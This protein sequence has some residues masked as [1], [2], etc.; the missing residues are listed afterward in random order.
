M[1]K[2]ALLFSIAWVTSV[3]ARE[4]MKIEDVAPLFNRAHN[5]VVSYFNQPYNLATPTQPAL[6]T[7]SD[8]GTSSNT[9]LIIPP[10]TRGTVYTLQAL[11]TGLGLTIISSSLG[12]FFIKSALLGHFMTTAK[13]TL[14]SFL[15]AQLA[16]RRKEEYQ[17][18]IPAATT[19]LSLLL[20]CR[21]LY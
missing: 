21:F 17:P 8:T 19:G 7:T 13:P 12:R 18:Y 15:H 10:S 1:K 11:G 6:L 9:S 3:S 14:D 4:M 5:W 2:I 16:K 20:A